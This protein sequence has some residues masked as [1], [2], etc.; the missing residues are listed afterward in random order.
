MLWSMSWA[1]YAARRR[2][3]AL[4]EYRQPCWTKTYYSQIGFYNQPGFWRSEQSKLDGQYSFLSSAE[5]SGGVSLK[6]ADCSGAAPAA[7]EITDHACRGFA[8]LI[9]LQCAGGGPS[10]AG[11]PCAAAG[12]H[13]DAVIGGV[14]SKAMLHPHWIRKRRGF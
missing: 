2:P 6:Q 4:S 11:P 8:L 5:H 1:R 13:A 10:A 3:Q 14:G 7:L 12:A 9:L